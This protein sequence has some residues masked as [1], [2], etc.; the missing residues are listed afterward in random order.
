MKR[1]RKPKYSQAERDQVYALKNNGLS[2]A[3]ISDETGL[4]EMQVQSIFNYTPQ[5]LEKNEGAVYQTNKTK[6]ETSG[7]HMLITHNSDRI[8]TIDQLL[9]KLDIDKDEWQILKA[10]VNKY[11][12]PTRNR[13]GHIEWDEGRMD[14]SMEY[15]AEAYINEI[16]QIKVSLV[17]IEPEQIRPTTQPVEIK[18]S[19]DKLE[20]NNIHANKEVKKVL[21]IA[22]P[23]F[24]FERNMR[25]GQLLPFH[26]RNVLSVALQMTHQ[27]KWDKI[28]FL[29]DI[30]DNTM[31]SDKFLKK[32]SY[33][34]TS[35]PALVEASWFIGKIRNYQPE[36]DIVVIEGNHD[37][38][39]ENFISK[40]FLSG[41]GLRAA[42]EIDEDA[43]MSVP[44]LLGLNSIGVEYYG[45]YPESSYQVYGD[46]VAIHGDVA[47]KPPGATSNA[48]SESSIMNKVFG[49][50]HRAEMVSR[51]VASVNGEQVF[52]FVSVPCSCK[53]DGTV[54]G[55]TREQNW[56]QGVGVSTHIGG[57]SHFEIPLF[58]SG[59]MLWNGR[60]WKPV[61]YKDALIEETKF[62]DK[63]GEDIT[64]QF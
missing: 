58:E 9:E 49:H 35:Q 41:Y 63:K 40:H 22:D 53:I 61:D 18:I 48:L 56:Q 11:E 13:K 25:S 54:P 21:Y 16:I 39:I 62:T 29:G 28:I 24:G 4:T 50:I 7:S 46:T 1:G 37:V 20:L 3:E 59:S 23:Q 30:L 64:W 12:V 2:R 26:D 47:R 34:F 38:R 14:G 15:E 17:K 44:K 5:D 32:P 55:S 57:Y 52:R 36:A 8:M 33:Y 31:F 60:I 45:N 19:G 10:V 51:K 27:Y 6:V 43:L 42:D